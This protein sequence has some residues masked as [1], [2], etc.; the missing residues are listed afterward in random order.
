[1]FK[2]NLET[3]TGHDHRGHVWHHLL[4]LCDRRLALA[5]AALTPFV[6]LI[7]LTNAFC[8]GFRWRMYP[9]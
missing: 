3:T 1:M 8:L 9:M 6:S 4:L 2:T 5:I 7:V